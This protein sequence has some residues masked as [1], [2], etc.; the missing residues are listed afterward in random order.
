MD[1]TLHSIWK[2]VRNNKK[3]ENTLSIWD[4]YCLG[5]SDDTEKVSQKWTKLHNVLMK[6]SHSHTDFKSLI[7]IN[8]GINN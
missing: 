7:L 3:M 8:Q 4:I 2:R 1:N 5:G 6:Y